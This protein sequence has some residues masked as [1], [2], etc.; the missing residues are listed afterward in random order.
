MA[1]AKKRF[2]PFSCLLATIYVVIVIGVYA[3]TLS[4]TNPP[5]TVGLD[6]AWW[7]LHGQFFYLGFIANAWIVYLLGAGFEYLERWANPHSSA[8]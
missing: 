7:V 3:V 6:C 8:P 5:G 4:T 2:V 1:T